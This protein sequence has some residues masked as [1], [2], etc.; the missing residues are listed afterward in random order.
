M[1]VS[2][3]FEYSTMLKN[4]GTSRSLRG[5]DLG[6]KIDRPSL[7]WRSTNIFKKRRHVKS[8]AKPKY[9]LYDIQFF[10]RLIYLTVNTNKHE[11]STLAQFTKTMIEENNHSIGLPHHEKI[12]K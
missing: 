4:C 9:F 10:V 12:T 11:K 7:S 8:L 6:S 3:Y 2:E 1:G 5:R